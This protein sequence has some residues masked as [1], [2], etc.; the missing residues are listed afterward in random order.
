MYVHLCIILLNSINLGIKYLN[1]FRGKNNYVFGQLYDFKFFLPSVNSYTF[2]RNL[3]I[4]RVETV[5]EK[6]YEILL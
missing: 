5:Y 2:S 3:K 4:L 1:S 6:S